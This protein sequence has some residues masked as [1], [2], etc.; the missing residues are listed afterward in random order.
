MAK[1]G[2]VAEYMQRVSSLMFLRFTTPTDVQTACSFR[3]EY[4][5]FLATVE[6][7]MLRTSL[8]DPHQGRYRLS[9]IHPE[10]LKFLESLFCCRGRFFWSIRHCE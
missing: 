8:D 7:A 10:V 4:S 3:E 5:V 6:P 2:S 1:L 9:I